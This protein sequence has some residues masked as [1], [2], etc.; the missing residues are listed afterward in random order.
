[1]ISND[2]VDGL[3]LNQLI[4]CYLGSGCSEGVVWCPIKGNPQCRLCFVYTIS[5]RYVLNNTY[6]LLTLSIKKRIKKNIYT[7][8]LFSL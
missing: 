1:M 6:F 5:W 2:R 8:V 3:K 4:L 7:F